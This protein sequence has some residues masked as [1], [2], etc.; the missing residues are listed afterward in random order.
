MNT[1]IVNKQ[2]ATIRSKKYNDIIYIKNE[3]V[4]T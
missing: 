2:K 3:K 4:T 1:L